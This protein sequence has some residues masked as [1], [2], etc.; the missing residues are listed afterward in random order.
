[1]TWK[2]ALRAALIAFLLLT[3]FAV[4][5]GESIRTMILAVLAFGAMTGAYYLLFNGLASLI[6]FILPWRI[7]P[8]IMT[9]VLLTLAIIS[10]GFGLTS[11]LLTLHASADGTPPVGLL[12]L[13]VPTGLTLLFRTRLRQFR[14]SH[15]RIT[16][17]ASSPATSAPSARR[18]QQPW[19]AEA[20]P[21]RSPWSGTKQTTPAGTASNTRTNDT[22]SSGQ[23]P[24]HEP[25]TETGTQSTSGSASS[26]QTIDDCYKLLGLQLGASLAEITSAYKKA[27][28][29]YHPDRVATMPPGFTEFTTER[30]KAINEAY[31]RLQAERV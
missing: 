17:P 25:G 8:L 15:P 12:M 6:H 23:G 16:R 24:Q 9:S 11:G 14:D 5:G 22:S 29:D 30:M 31:R 7:I 28:F 1:M 3:G 4:W 20:A 26:A 27:V 21:N 18:Q 10:C 2:F 19:Q 13:S